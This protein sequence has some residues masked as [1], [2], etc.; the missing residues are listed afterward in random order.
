VIGS[1]TASL[2]LSRSSVRLGYLVALPPVQVL[3]LLAK[4]LFVAA[5]SAPR[6][7]TLRCRPW[8]R[9]L[10]RSSRGAVS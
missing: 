10:A 9:F 1:A 5:K 4:P 2:D 7:S 3:L 6:F 8:P